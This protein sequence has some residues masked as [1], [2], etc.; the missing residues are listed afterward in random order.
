MRPGCWPP[1]HITFA[2]AYL[3]GLTTADLT[4]GAETP[5]IATRTDQ[6][7]TVTAGLG[8]RW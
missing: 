8:L 1:A 4:D 6:S 7:H 5:T 3:G 2:L